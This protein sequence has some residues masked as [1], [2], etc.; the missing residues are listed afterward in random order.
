[1]PWGGDFQTNVFYQYGWGEL[2]K[3]PS[4]WYVYY[5]DSEQFG[6][7][8]QVRLQTVG[9]G[10]SQTWSDTTVLRASVGKQIG[11]NV[12]R[13]YNDGKDA[14]ESDKDYRLWFEAIYYF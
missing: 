8:N 7:D 11:D 5:P 4:A 2:Y 6:E 10:L 9:M 3:D 14:D 13:Q 12:L 1:M